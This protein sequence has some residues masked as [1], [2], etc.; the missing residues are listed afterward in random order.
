MLRCTRFV[1]PYVRMSSVL[2]LLGSSA[3]QQTLQIHSLL[4]REIGQ[5]FQNSTRSIGAGG[6]YRNLPTAILQLRR[7]KPDIICAWGAPAL[8]AAVVARHRR[9]LF[10]P[11]RFAGPRALRW[12]R[13]L[14]DRADVTMICPTFTQQKLAVSRGIDPDRCVVI[15]PGVDL[16]ALGSGRNPAFRAELGFLESDFVLIAPGESTIA[17]GHDLAV[18]A[19]V[20]LSVLDPAFKLLLW[21]RGPR[22]RLVTAMTDRLHLDALVTVAERKLRRSVS[23]EE[24]AGVADVCLATPCGVTPTLSI[25]TAMAAGVPI[26]STVTS[27]LAELLEDRHSALMAPK[28]SPRALVRLVLDLRADPAMR[29]KIIENARARA[30]EHYSMTK[31][32]A[33][34]R[35][36]FESKLQGASVES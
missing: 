22:A 17:T 29:A 1:V 34:Y 16:G 30:Y 7:E 24:L 3:D 19:A 9:I 25:A 5:P 8:A 36:L 11:D 28:R 32:V 14:S 35:R 18:W 2:H 23:F 12:I 21:G 27:T 33:G 13:W 10:S 20:V 4:V 31:M 26:V 6:T 15:P